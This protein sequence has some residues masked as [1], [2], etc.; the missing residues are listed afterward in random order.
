MPGP[1]GVPRADI[2]A[3]LAEGHSDRYIGRTLRTNPKRVGRIRAELDLPRITPVGLTL[4]QTWAT[5]TRPAADGH[6]EW[7]GYFREGT[8]PIV[9]HGNQAFSARR[10][11]FLTANGQE[12][13]GRVLAG[14]GWA[15]CV[16]PDHMEDARLRALY[17]TVLGDVA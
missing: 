9:S 1:V 6:L 12:P 15:P 4:E 2:V 14:C 10:I 13:R 11:A 7:A 5:Y 17:A 16:A 8:C 3:L